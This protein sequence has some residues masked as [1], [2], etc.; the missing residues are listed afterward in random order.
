M[1]L[2]THSV[3]CYRY[4]PWLRDRLQIIDDW[5]LRPG[6]W[7]D[8]EQERYEA[9]EEENDRQGGRKWN[10]PDYWEAALNRNRALE[11]EK[12]LVE[13]DFD[14]ILRDA[15]GKRFMYGWNI[16]P[17]ERMCAIC[18]FHNDDDTA[19]HIFDANTPERRLELKA[20][21]L[22]CCLNAPFIKTMEIPYDFTLTE[23]YLQDL[24][25]EYSVSKIDQKWQPVRD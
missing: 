3:I 21:Y 12:S 13:I 23:E 5:R 6:H 16:E 11:P 15:I 1:Y 2:L 25:M 9:E 18:F 20:F 17:G 24:F 19:N 7:T 22:E 10:D 8:E 14:Y 4:E